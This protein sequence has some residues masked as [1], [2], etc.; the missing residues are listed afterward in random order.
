MNCGI[1]S[2]ALLNFQ[3]FFSLLEFINSLMFNLSQVSELSPEE[4]EIT[5]GAYGKGISH[6]IIGLKT[7]KGQKQLKLDPTIYDALIKEKVFIY[8]IKTFVNFF[9]SCK[10][11]KSFIFFILEWMFL[12]NIFFD[13]FLECMLNC[14]MLYFFYKCFFLFYFLKCM[15]FLVFWRLLELVRRWLTRGA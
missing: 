2:V 5:T 14:N 8:F 6:V 13:K 11:L 10:N 15:L 12:I 7:V 9:C 3:V 4:A 1:F